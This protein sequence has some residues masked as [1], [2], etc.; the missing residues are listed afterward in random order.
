MNKNN[1]LNAHVD[2]HFSIIEAITTL[3]ALNLIQ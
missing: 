3:Y 1:Y 2:P